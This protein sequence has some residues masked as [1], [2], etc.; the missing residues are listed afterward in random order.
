MKKS[1]LESPCINQGFNPVSNS[2][3]LT[4]QPTI[5]QQ[6]NLGATAKNSGIHTVDTTPKIPENPLREENQTYKSITKYT[7]II[8]K[9]AATIVGA[10]ILIP[11][12]AIAG[13]IRYTFENTVYFYKHY[14]KHHRG[15]VVTQREHLRQQSTALYYCLLV[16]INKQKERLLELCQRHNINIP[17]D[18]ENSL[19]ESRN[20]QSPPSNQLSDILGMIQRQ[21]KQVK[22]F[23]SNLLIPDLNQEDINYAEQIFNETMTGNRDE[24]SLTALSVVFDQQYTAYQ[25]E[26]INLNL[27]NSLINEI[28][29]LSD[30]QRRIERELQSINSI[31]G[32]RRCHGCCVFCNYPPF[33][34]IPSLPRAIAF[35]LVSFV[36]YLAPVGL[37][38]GAINTVCL[39]IA[40]IWDTEPFIDP[41]P[42]GARFP[43]IDERRIQQQTV[44]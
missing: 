19:S 38:F 27:E 12:G 36:T 33:E 37:F 23:T 29:L 4:D 20:T 34:Y 35:S 40:L 15:S 2:F 17:T 25:A 39:W 16:R 10:I 14:H 13:I 1:D 31:S 26:N 44:P 42:W 41:F 28:E 24:V 3:T 9:V 43:R 8:F 6:Q 18:S 30:T 32:R 11:I 5:P 7:I 21:I 22:D